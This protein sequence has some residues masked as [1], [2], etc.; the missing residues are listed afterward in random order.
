MGNLQW[1]AD[2]L[3]TN[4]KNVNSGKLSWFLFGWFWEVETTTQGS[5]WCAFLFWTSWFH[6]V[7]IVLKVTAVLWANTCNLLTSGRIGKE[8]LLNF[9]KYA[10]LALLWLAVLE[11]IIFLLFALNEIL[12]F[13]WENVASHNANWRT[14]KITWT[15]TEAVWEMYQAWKGF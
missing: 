12:L 11:E 5:K 6:L 2:W 3:Y 13:L 15:V 10:L 7:W 9:C 14:L 4:E 1:T 8:L